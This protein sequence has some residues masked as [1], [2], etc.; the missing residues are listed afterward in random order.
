MKSFKTIIRTVLAAMAAMAAFACQEGIVDETGKELLNEDLVISVDVEDIT[1]TTAKIKVTHNGSKDDT[2]YGFLTE[3]VDL[4][5]EVL[6]ELEVKAFAEGQSEEGL[7]P[8][9][10]H[11]HSA[12][13]GRGFR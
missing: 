5:E 13:R 3:Y 9:V 2:W 1:Y 8:G 10:G 12:Q 4:E 11:P 7:R 6:I